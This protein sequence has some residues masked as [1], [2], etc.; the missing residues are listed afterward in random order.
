MLSDAPG[1]NFGRN[2]RVLAVF[3]IYGRPLKLAVSTDWKLGAKLKHVLIPPHMRQGLR[4]WGAASEVYGKPRQN[5]PLLPSA[6]KGVGVHPRQDPRSTGS[7]MDVIHQKAVTYDK[8]TTYC[9]QP[10]LEEHTCW[11]TTGC[12]P[13]PRPTDS[14]TTINA[15]AVLKK[16]SPTCWWTARDGKY[17]G[18][19]YGKRLAMRSPACQ[20]CWEVL[21][22][23]GEVRLTTLHEPKQ[24]SRIGLCGVSQRFRGRAPRR[25]PNNRNGN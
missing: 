8:W 12:P 10:T 7:R 15:R 11:S 17:Y 25:Q 13:T 2:F 3:W 1:L 9:Q 4:Y 21:E 16:Q 20:A 14:A 24:W 22:T 6:H 18:G 5:T 19:N 23:R